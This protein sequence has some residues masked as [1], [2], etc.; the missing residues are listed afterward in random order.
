MF[1]VEKVSPA[2]YTRFLAVRG[3]VEASQAQV[4]IAQQ[5]FAAESATAE[6]VTEL[7]T[8]RYG[9]NQGDQIAEDGTIHRQAP[10]PPA[11]SEGAAD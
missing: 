7:M 5:L 4:Q 6:A 1:K 9:L 2:D 10:A 3:R 8:E 11:E